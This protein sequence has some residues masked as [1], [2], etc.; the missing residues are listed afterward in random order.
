MNKILIELDNRP[1]D[2]GK[3]YV[4]P[5]LITHI[6]QHVDFRTHV[7]VNATAI[8]LANG[9]TVVVAGKPDEVYGIINT[10]AKS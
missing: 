5:R 9:E 4:N 8:H 7:S 10:K 6:T 1:V 2:G 3:S